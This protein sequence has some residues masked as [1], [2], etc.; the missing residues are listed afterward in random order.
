MVCSTGDQIVTVTAMRFPLSMIVA[1]GVLL[2]CGHAR[3]QPFEAI[4]HGLDI[5]APGGLAAQNRACC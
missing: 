4:Q 1:I 2:S 3:A 5:Q